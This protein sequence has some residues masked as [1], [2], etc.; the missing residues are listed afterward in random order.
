MTTSRQAA[1]ATRATLACGEGA[2]TPGVS[3]SPHF[4]SFEGRRRADRPT[5]EESGRLSVAPPS[6]HSV[7]NL[8]FPS[9]VYKSPGWAAPHDSEI[10]GGSPTGYPQRAKPANPHQLGRPPKPGR[11]GVGVPPRS[12]IQVCRGTHCLVTVKD[13][14]EATIFAAT[15]RA[16]SDDSQR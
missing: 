15:P 12:R 8:A 6:R 2:C 5:G 16:S 13:P 4:L 7:K 9:G 11:P 10:E 1:P 14:R 3:E